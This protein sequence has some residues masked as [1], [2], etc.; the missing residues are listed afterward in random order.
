L[1]EKQFIGKLDSQ[2]KPYISGLTKKERLME[3]THN[4]KWSDHLKN[5][6]EMKEKIILINAIL[7][8][9]QKTSIFIRKPNEKENENQIPFCP[10][11]FLLYLP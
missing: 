3:E 5:A 9:N 10:N 11:L 8:L 7:S 1:I 4:L 6:I 2:D